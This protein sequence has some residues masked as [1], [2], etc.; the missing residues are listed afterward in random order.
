MKMA[1]TWA[2][3]HRTACQLI[4]PESEK[5][6]R[7]NSITSSPPHNWHEAG[8]CEHE[9]RS[10][11]GRRA[12]AASCAQGRGW[13]RG[14]RRGPGPPRAHRRRQGGAPGK[15]SARADRRRRC[16]RGGG[17]AICGRRRRPLPRPW[18]WR[19]SGDAK[20]HCGGGG[21]C[22]SPGVLYAAA[23][24]RTAPAS[25][26][27]VVVR[28]DWLTDESSLRKKSDGFGRVLGSWTDAID[29]DAF[30]LFFFFLRII[31]YNE[32]LI[33]H[34]HSFLWTHACKLYHYEYLRILDR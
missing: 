29:G 2:S 27:L 21:G 17:G 16:G 30:L 19:C 12:A 7:V 23:A 1:E 24:G 18:W 20:R 10:W 28:I 26:A 11:A 22:S 32:T 31:R 13:R 6:A 14:A 4:N 5:H 25:R 15:T 9:P 3:T 34:A 33:T 8:R